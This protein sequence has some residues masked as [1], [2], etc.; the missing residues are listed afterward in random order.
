MMQL[1]NKAANPNLLNLKDFLNYSIQGIAKT[2]TRNRATALRRTNMDDPT[3]IYV[4]Q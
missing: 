4:N 3:K 2:L 1:L